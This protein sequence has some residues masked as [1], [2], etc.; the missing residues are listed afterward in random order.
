M[1]ASTLLLITVCGPIVQF[2]EIFLPHFLQRMPV[3]QLFL[4]TAFEF[5]SIAL[6]VETLEAYLHLFLQTVISIIFLSF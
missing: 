2:H 3:L 6:W 1:L 5:E 4:I